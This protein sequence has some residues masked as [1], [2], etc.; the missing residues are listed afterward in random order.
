MCH[1]VLTTT[2]KYDPLGNVY[3]T[4]TE[5]FTC[6]LDIYLGADKLIPL[7]IYIFHLLFFKINYMPYSL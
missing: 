6:P 2:A 3:L 7:P 4:A 5:C 1:C